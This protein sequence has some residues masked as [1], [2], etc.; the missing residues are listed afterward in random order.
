MVDSMSCFEAHPLEYYGDP[1]HLDRPV[2]LHADAEQLYRIPRYKGAKDWVLEGTSLDDMAQQRPGC[3]CVKCGS[4]VSMERPRGRFWGYYQC[5]PKQSSPPNEGEYFLLCSYRTFAFDLSA[6]RWE[7]VNVENVDIDVQPSNVFSELVLPK[8]VRE[9]VRALAKAYERQG[10][11][12]RLATDLIRGKGL[13]TIFLLHGPPGVGKTATAES[14][15]EMTNR[16]L[17]SLTCGD[18]GTDGAQVEEKLNKYLKWG[19]SWGAVVLLDEAD[20][21]I[22]GPDF[23]NQSAKGIQSFSNS[24]ISYVLTG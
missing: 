16:P 4:N 1:T 20:G 17:L 22:T 18:L 3:N 5:D 2:L 9:T 21:R 13:G 15:A 10:P 6:R 8:E 14:V 11:G 24:E 19:L 7:V 23:R 12:K